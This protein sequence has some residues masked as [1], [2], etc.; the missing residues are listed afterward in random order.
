MSDT[1]LAAL[2]AAGAA[3][4]GA[5]GG[6]YTES[7]SSKRVMKQKLRDERCICYSELIQQY[8]LLNSA[9]NAFLSTPNQLH[10]ENV[11]NANTNFGIAYCRAILICEKIHIQN[12]SD[13]FDEVQI[14]VNTQ[15]VPQT[16][17]PKYRAATEAMRE[18]LLP[19]KTIFKRI[20]EFFYQKLHSRSTYNKGDR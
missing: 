20:Y 8:N 1:V 5:F 10:W 19:R 17:Q 15:E 18:E 11:N 9:M 13:Y 14:F 12:L 6:S 4:L 16:L 3:L 2:I 7:L